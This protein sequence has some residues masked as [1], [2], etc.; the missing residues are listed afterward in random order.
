MTLLDLIFTPCF[1]MIIYSFARYKVNKNIKSNPY[2]KYYMPGLFAKLFGGFCV[3][4]I[5]T[6]YYKGGDTIN[7]FY[8]DV[9]MIKL[10][11][12]SP[13][14]FLS[15]LGGNLNENNH[16]MFDQETGWPNYWNDHHSFFVIRLTS[17]IC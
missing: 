13:S 9:T 12:K 16:L 6:F 1:L 5:Y 14:T 8:S 17:L 4:I 11:V 7:F 10:L 2:Y 15:I 3:C